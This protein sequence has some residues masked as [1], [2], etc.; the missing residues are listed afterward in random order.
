MN[1]KI[2]QLAHIISTPITS[3]PLQHNP[4]LARELGFVTKHGQEDTRKDYHDTNRNNSNDNN[5]DHSNDTSNSSNNENSNNSN[6]FDANPWSRDA[7]LTDWKL[8]NILESSSLNHVDLIGHGM[9]NNEQHNNEN[10]V[11]ETSRSYAWESDVDVKECRGCRRRFGLIVRRHHCRCCGLIH[12]DRCTQSRA[13]LEP[14][15][16]IQDPHNTIEPLEML[17]S[18]HQRVCDLCYARLS[19]LPP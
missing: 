14:S 8:S 10:N 11:E 2:A 5:G 17:A 12:C 3:K 9:E 19:G 18:H 1:A 7:S 4:E 13:Y 6:E 16:I 15:Q